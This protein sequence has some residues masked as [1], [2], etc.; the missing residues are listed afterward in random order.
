M[1]FDYLTSKSPIPLMSITEVLAKELEED[2]DVDVVD[3]MIYKELV[4]GII[5][6]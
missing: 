2:V 5:R 4:R 1:F 3:N 6:D